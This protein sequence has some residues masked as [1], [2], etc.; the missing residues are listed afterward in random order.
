MSQEFNSA[1]MLNL[2]W[3]WKKQLAVVLIVAIAAAAIG[4]SSF[5][6]KPKYKSAASAYPINLIPYGEESTTEQ[7]LSLLKSIAVRDSVIAKLQL[8]KHYHIDA[9]S[10]MGKSYLLEEWSENIS[11]SNTELEAAEIK[12][13]DT[14]PDTACLIVNEILRQG[15]LLARKLQRKSAL[16][17]V[18]MYSKQVAGIKHDIDSME[19]L[20]KILRTDYGVTE[21]DAQ[22]KEV[23]KG[24]LKV[25]GASSD[26]TKIANLEAVKMMNNFREK[27]GEYLTLKNRINSSKEYYFSKLKEFNMVQTDLNKELT[28]SN[29]V[30]QP[31][32]ANKKSYPVRWLIVLIATV[33]SLFFALV[34]IGYIDRKNA[35]KEVTEN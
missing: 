18:N 29:V 30:S 27:G 33:S 21:F 8:D 16:E 11:I 1:S 31:V 32:P 22:V 15:N 20:I 13:L 10:P 23:T 24:Y 35:F 28:Y 26:V 12:V 19:A 5:F 2:I 25:A 3:K 7:L 9:S 4:S 14:D 17:L 6:I 34:V